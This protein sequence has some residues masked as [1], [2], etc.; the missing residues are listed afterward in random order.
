MTMNS[1]DSP[2]DESHDVHVLLAVAF[3]PDGRDVPAVDLVPG[4][5]AGF[6]R[7]QRRTRA[8]TGVGSVAVLALAGTAYAMV[9]A[10]QA[11]SAGSASG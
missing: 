8:V 9:A 11:P 5:V 10:R 2:L 4:A 6:G 7:R 1:P 3:D